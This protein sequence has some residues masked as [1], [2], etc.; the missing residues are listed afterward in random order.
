MCN[1]TNGRL[2]IQSTGAVSVQAET[3]FSN[4]QCFTSLEGAS[5]T[6]SVVGFSALTLINGWTNAPFSTHQ[7]AYRT[8]NGLVQFMGAIAT[9]GSN[10]SPF[11]LPAGARPAKPLYIKVDLCNATNGRLF[12]QP[13]GAVTV[14]AATFSNAQCFTSLEGA[15]FVK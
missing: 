4:A 3:N 2:I 11:T 6:P 8:N 14:Q 13:N 10:A 7:A 5:F 9:S 15:S 1:A 12:I